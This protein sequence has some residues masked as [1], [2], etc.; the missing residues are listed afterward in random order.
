MITLFLVEYKTTGNIDKAR[1]MVVTTSVMYQMFF[2]FSC[3][4]NRSLKEINLF[5]NKYLLGAVA[6]TIIGQILIIY[7]PLSKVFDF[8]PLTLKEWLIITAAS[9]IGFIF[10]ET[11]KL[12][13]N[14]N[15]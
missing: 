11:K 12:I 15:N 7:T 3:K 13:K 14:R 9:S 2:V 6:L 10:F 5:G 8:V 4:S 1:T